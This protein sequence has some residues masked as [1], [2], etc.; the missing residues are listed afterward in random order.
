M[1]GVFASSILQTFFESYHDIAFN[2]LLSAHILVI[3]SLGLEFVCAIANNLTFK[4]TLKSF[5]MQFIFNKLSTM[6]N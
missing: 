6:T 5:F 4:I 1:G 2:K 3:V